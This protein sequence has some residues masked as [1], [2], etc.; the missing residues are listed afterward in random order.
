[1]SQNGV[2]VHSEL[3]PPPPSPT[4]PHSH[5]LSPHT[6]HTRLLAVSSFK[7]YVMAD[8]RKAIRFDKCDCQLS[9]LG[10]KSPGI[11][12]EH[13]EKKPVK[14][15]ATTSS[16]EGGGGGRGGRERR[17]RRE[18]REGGRGGEEGGKEKR[19]ERRE[20]RRREG[21][22]E[23]EEGGRESFKVAVFI[24]NYGA[25][26]CPPQPHHCSLVTVLHGCKLKCL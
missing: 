2:V 5:I 18:G 19:G 10:V 20:G 21:E 12:V 6:P 14:Q 3:Y 16:E 17:E 25:S 26:L 9:V 23:E 15:E 11:R 22:G 7:T 8:L 4:P 1:M 13:L 24:M